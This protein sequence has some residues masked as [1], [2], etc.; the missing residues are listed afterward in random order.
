MPEKRTYIRIAAD[1]SYTTHEEDQGGDSARYHQLKAM[2]DGGWLEVIRFSAAGCSDLKLVIDEEGRLK[3][4]PPN[5]R[6][7]G[8]VGPAIIAMQGLSDEGEADIRG[9]NSGRLARILGDLERTG[10]AKMTQEEAEAA[11]PDTAIRV[12]RMN[13]DGSRGEEVTD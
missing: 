8:I 10:D 1:G 2:L 3:D 6:I 11:L 13:P 4:L 7:R 9:L 12:Y 5:L